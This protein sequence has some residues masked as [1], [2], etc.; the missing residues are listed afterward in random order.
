MIDAISSKS[1]R[2]SSESRRVDS[3]KNKSL[4]GGIVVLPFFMAVVLSYI[5]FAWSSPPIWIQDLIVLSPPILVGIVYY[6]KT[7][8]YRFRAGAPLLAMA[9]GGALFFPVVVS[10]HLGDFNVFDNGIG[11]AVAGCTGAFA[12]HFIW[13]VFKP[14]PDMFWNMVL[15]RFRKG[16]L[17]W[18]TILIVPLIW[19]G[20]AYGAFELVD[21]QFDGKIG[22]V[23]RVPVTE[24]AVRPRGRPGPEY[25]VGLAPWRFAPDGAVLMLGAAVPQADYQQLAV[26][27][28]ACLTMHQGFLD[29]AWYRVGVCPPLNPRQPRAAS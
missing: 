25:H 13:R 29:A 22:Q 3:S 20:Y 7:W 28:V 24:K 16:R 15:E 9:L 12:A 6:C 5:Y 14:S 8:V 2:I 27:R 18:A 10:V 23:F 1:R 26:G 21:T 11:L 4:R 19:A 17:R